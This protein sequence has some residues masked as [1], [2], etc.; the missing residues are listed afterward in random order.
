MQLVLLQVVWLRVPQHVPPRSGP[1]LAACVSVGDGW[2]VS[3]GGA[4]VIPLSVC[5][6]LVTMPCS[7]SS[8]SM[9]L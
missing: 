2:V 8:S 3:Q 1:Q 9:S 5:Q 4:G 6:E 7:S